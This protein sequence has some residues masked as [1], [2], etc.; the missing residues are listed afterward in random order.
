MR[1]ATDRIHVRNEV[2]EMVIPVMM[3]GGWIR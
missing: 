1:K 3:R 2:K